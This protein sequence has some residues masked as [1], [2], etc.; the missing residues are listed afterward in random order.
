MQNPFQ[1]LLDRL[2]RL[3]EL[4]TRSLSKNYSASDVEE[5]GGLPLAQEITRLSKPRIY[6]LVSARKIPHSKR[7]NKLY[8]NRA[9]LLAWVSA[10]KRN[11]N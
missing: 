4:I 5:I 8:F 1:I 2:E 11:E 6:A 7:G 9:E 10:G 3:E